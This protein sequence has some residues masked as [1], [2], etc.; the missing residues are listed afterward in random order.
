MVCFFLFVSSTI[1]VLVILE[2]SSKPIDTTL[3]SKDT[4]LKSKSAISQLV[5]TTIRSA[6]AKN[7]SAS[8]K[9]DKLKKAS[10]AS[11]V[12]QM[13]PT[14]NTAVIRKFNLDE[15]FN[16]NDDELQF[17]GADAK[18]ERGA[19]DTAT[20]STTIDDPFF[21]GSVYKAESNE[22]AQDIKVTHVEPMKKLKRARFVPCS[23]FY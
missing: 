12:Q 18:S 19:E 13:K 3:Q 21:I 16:G 23:V 22:V 7:K 5:S 20:T 17:N 6:V 1:T 8:A 15:L 14:L 4:K 11:Q 10:L 2:K 9:A